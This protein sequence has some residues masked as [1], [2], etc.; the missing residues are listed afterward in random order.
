[1]SDCVPCHFTGAGA[2]PSH[3][4]DPALADRFSEPNV[5]CEACHGP[6]A[7]HSDSLEAEDIVVDA[8]S[9]VC[10][11]CH[12]SAGK[13]LPQDDLHDTHDLVQ[14]WNRD[15]HVLGVR[16]RSHNAFCS[17]CHSPY[18]RGA[19]TERKEGAATRV[20]SETSGRSPTW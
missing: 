5:G 14:N 13:I 10:G 20:F 2:G 15:P 7:K 12:T 9:R 11:S 8:S 4:E 6:G 19:F 1:M 17:D 16:F 18:E 3:P